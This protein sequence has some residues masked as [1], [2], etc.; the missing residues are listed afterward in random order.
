MTLPTP[1][2]RTRSPGRKTAVAVRLAQ[3]A[4]TNQAA[5]TNQTFLESYGQTVA[6]LGQALNGTNTQLTNQQLV[7]NMLLRQRESVSG[8]SIDEEMTDL[9]KFQRAFEASA[10]LIV[11]VDEMLQTVLSL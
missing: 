9:I 10:K 1:R 4:D 7:E 5:L 3:L 6:A 2:L 8:V 11:T